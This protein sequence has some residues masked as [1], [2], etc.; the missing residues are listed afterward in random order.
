MS[1]II[2]T[3]AVI[4]RTMDY[5][6]TSKILTLYTRHSGKM[7][8]MVKGARQRKNSFGSTL[9]PLSFISAVIYTKEGRDLQ[10]LTESDH[11]KV[12]RAIPASLEKMAAGL[13]MLE[14]VHLVTHDGEENVP[15]FDLLVGTITALDGE[16][17]YPDLLLAYFEIRL[18]DVLGFR[19]VLDR[20]VLCGNEIVR[21]NEAGDSV[22]DLPR[23]GLLCQSCTTPMPARERISHEMSDLLRLFLR[24]P[25]EVIAG[26][27]EIG[28]QATAALK[29]FT[30]MFLRYHVHG[31]RVLK[32]EK[33]F[34]AV[35]QT[36]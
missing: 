27:G 19:P 28:D 34:S 29:N 6:E 14:I 7:G 9:E 10:L 33:I 21:N 17:R 8:V 31:L 1:T 4:L 22:F 5:R 23:G 24:H 13:A 20:C 35:H 12:F 25:P 36:V 11:L 15:L 2:K 16:I 3:E 18:A 26:L 30:W 32:T